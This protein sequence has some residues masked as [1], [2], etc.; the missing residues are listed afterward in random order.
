MLAPRIEF[1]FEAVETVLL[2]VFA[3][4]EDTVCAWVLADE[5]PPRRK[6]QVVG[7][8]GRANDA[9]RGSRGGEGMV[10]MVG[11]D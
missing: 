9:R 8:N 6:D 4:L 10:V 11:G 1:D 2:R 7:D 3:L 5:E